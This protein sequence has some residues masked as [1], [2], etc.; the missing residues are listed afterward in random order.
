VSWW[1]IGRFE[2]SP[3]LEKQGEQKMA[4][5]K[6]SET[7]RKLFL[8]ERLKANQEAAEKEALKINMKA[9]LASLD[10]EKEWE[11]LSEDSN[12]NP[13][14]V[15]ACKELYDSIMKRLS[16]K[17]YASLIANL[18]NLRTKGKNRGV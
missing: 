15:A 4:T 13:E 5:K 12:L 17:I 14:T 8:P 16:K 2:P 18:R 11:D 3:I 9:S 6:W 1:L 7:K 10:F